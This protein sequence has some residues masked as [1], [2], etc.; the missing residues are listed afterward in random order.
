MLR[1]M[2]GIVVPAA[3]GQTMREV[4]GEAGSEWIARLPALV[5]ECAHRW[6]LVIGEPFALSYNYVVS[7]K[8]VGGDRVVLKLGFPCRELFSET[9][10]LRVYAGDGAVR[11][12][13]ADESLGAMLLDHLDPGTELNASADD[14]QA[15]VAAAKV[16]RALWKPVPV[17][18]QFPSI[19]DWG[20]GFARLRD[21][22][23][24]GT[25]P[26][27]AR[28]VDE[29]QEL[30]ESLAATSAEP[31]VLHGDLHHGNILRSGDGW[32]AIDPK[33]VIG[34]P[35]YEAGALLRNPHPWLW[36]QPDPVAITA[37]RLDLLSAALGF[38]RERL[39]GWAIAQAVLSAWWTFEDHQHPGELA[40]LCAEWLRKA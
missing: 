24:G 12:R 1:R 26:F 3:F 11:L 38:D 16:M 10:A 35:A 33:G 25:G 27:E 23:G 40:L 20:R 32:L 18:H 21:R 6:S 17:Q 15:T 7:A 14:V 13:D 31:V 34:E 37:R 29:A 5:A 22:F 8:T 36:D 39:R 9:A 2:T 30:F 4:Y 28:V 19:Q